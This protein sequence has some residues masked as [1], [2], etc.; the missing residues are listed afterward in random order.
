MSGLQM[1]IEHRPKTTKA[2]IFLSAVETSFRRFRSMTYYAYTPHS[3]G[4]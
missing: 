4:S 3:T 1:V 2:N